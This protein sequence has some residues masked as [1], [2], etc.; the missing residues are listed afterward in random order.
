MLPRRRTVTLLVVLCLGHILLISAQVPGSSGSSLL[1]SAA[2]G[3]VGGIQRT[4]GG[5]AGGIRGFWAHYVALGG[6]ARENDAL[7]ARVLQLEA[8]LEGER[9]RGAR[10]DELEDALKLQR[11]TVA[12]TLAAQVIAG[13]PMPGVLTI[14]LDRGTADGVRANMAVINDRGVVGRSSAA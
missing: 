9:A 2:L 6:A 7:R 13:N 5:A 12:P 14:N 8:R 11:S 10:V 3:S 4:I 1:G